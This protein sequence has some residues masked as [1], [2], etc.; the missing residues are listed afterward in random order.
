MLTRAGP[1]HNAAERDGDA[2]GAAGPAA[3]T[4]ET[5]TGPAHRPTPSFWI[6]M[7]VALGYPLGDPR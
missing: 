1:A 7:T 3:A 2:W 4:A 6:S 5:A